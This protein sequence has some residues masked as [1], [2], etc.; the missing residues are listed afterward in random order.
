VRDCSKKFE[1]DLYPASPINKFN[2]LAS[3]IKKSN[4]S[5]MFTQISKNLERH[6]HYLASPIKKSND[7]AIDILAVWLIHKLYEAK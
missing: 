1:N 6:Y 5:D 3:W 4:N 7:N 2:S